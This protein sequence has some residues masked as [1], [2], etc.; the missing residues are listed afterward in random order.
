MKRKIVRHGSSSLTVTLPIKWIERYKLKKGDEIDIEESGSNLIVSTKEESSPKKKIIKKDSYPFNKNNLSHLYQLGYDEI[1][2]EIEDSKMIDEIKERLPYCTGYEIID[3]KN[4]TLFIKSI[5]TT[6]DSEFDNLFRKTFLLTEEMGK[7]IISI[8]ESNNFDKIKEIRN[9]ESINNKF[10]DI[11]IRIL[12][13]RGYKIQ[14]RTMQI[15]EVVKDLEKI[16]DEFKYI[17]D[18]LTKE[19]KLNKNLL[20][21]LKDTVNYFTIFYKLFYTHEKKLKEEIYSKRK[22]LLDN[23]LKQIQSAKGKEALFIHYLINITQKT[24]EATGG[25]FSLNL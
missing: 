12:N 25:Y 5:V 16:A 2:I 3:Q 22:S 6:L 18:F 10:S 24:Y 20:N 23:L 1:E 9:L 21:S 11:C 17:C 4:N 19:K 13:K 8:V 15:Y 14:N 7:E